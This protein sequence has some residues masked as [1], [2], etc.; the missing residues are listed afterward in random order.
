VQ[1][2][3]TSVRHR[4]TAQGTGQQ[5]LPLIYE[6][7]QNGHPRFY[8]KQVDANIEFIPDDKGAIPSLILHQAGHD[9]P[10]KRQ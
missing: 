1:H 9:T 3:V 2:L 5:A 6:G 10:A 4:L 7:Q 8:V